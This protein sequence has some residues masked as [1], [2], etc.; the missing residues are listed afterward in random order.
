M[1]GILGVAGNGAPEFVP[2]FTTAL[3]TLVHRGPD[4]SGVWWN[5]KYSVGLGHRRLSIIDLTSRGHQ[6]MR[7]DLTGVTVV[8]N[9][10][11]YNYRDLHVELEECG[12][13][14]S[15][16]SDTEVLLAAYLHWGTD[17][18]EKLNGM[19]AFGIFD[20][21]KNQLFL[22][23]D[24][25]GE[26]PV[27]YHLYNDTLVFA[28]E[29]KAILEFPGFKRRVDSPALNYY[30]A[31][32][33]SPKDQ[34]LVSGVKKLPPA[35]ALLFDLSNS[36]SKI[37][38]YWYLP[39]FI[40]VNGRNTSIQELS[41]QLED[42]LEKAISRQ[43]VSDVPLA[44]LLSGGLDSSLI[45][46]LAARSIPN[47]RTFNV[48]QPD[49]PDF[50]ERAHAR[51]IADHFGTD[52]TELELRKPAVNLLDK[53]AYHY[54]DPINDA[55]MIPSYLICQLIKNSCTVAIGGDGGDELFGGYRRY[56]K[57]LKA[58]RQLSWLP[59]FL[60]RTLGMAL[61]ICTFGDRRFQ[62]AVKILR[63]PFQMDGMP[64]A[65]HLA[66]TERNRMAKVPVR[67]DSA[68]QLFM[69]NLP[70]GVKGA[71]SM[72]RIDF[73]NYLPED[74]LVKVD[75]ASMANSVEL[76]SPLLDRAVTEFAFKDVPSTMKADEIQRKIILKYL[77]RKVLPEMFDTHRKQ[78][79]SVPYGQWF[80]AASWKEYFKDHVMSQND[81]PFNRLYIE[82]LLKSVG[83]QGS[84]SHPIL[85]SL[86]MFERWRQLYRLSF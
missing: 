26:K 27:F 81:S 80:Q 18:L 46:A 57:L 15:S 40:P 32:G 84:V 4:D 55:S 39:D 79:F 76:R 41:G 13:Q 24:R 44:V 60:R 71:D 53:L 5:R 38:K 50:D 33:F 19:F 86:V 77:A 22:A 48:T 29:L 52:H 6:P 14:F 3:S 17:C 65:Y 61:G 42:L 70:S 45:T 1:C 31:F 34:S 82:R 75:R 54:D 16:Q 23:R 64:A 49:A 67:G 59:I 63:S 35:H 85:F 78:G 74:L 43:L 2:Y 62:G 83:Q 68:E 10:E 69:A 37:W 7:D 28:S 12:H 73:E 21:R 58:R 51:L 20:E 8:F 11:I 66:H 47:V 9:G 25:A 72:T 56:N 36:R 30:L